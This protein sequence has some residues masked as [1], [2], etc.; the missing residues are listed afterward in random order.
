MSNLTR[1]LFVIADAEHAR[2]VRIAAN[3]ALHTVEAFDSV[4][5]HRRPSDLGSDH[6]GAA[7]HSTS[8][9]H[10]AFVPR[11]DPQ[12]VASH[13][14][15]AAIS[16]E[17]NMAFARG[18]FDRLVLAALPHTA[19]VLSERLST[20]AASVLIGTLDKDLVKTP[21]DALSTHLRAWLL[22]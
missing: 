21:D 22:E 6:P 2:F 16:D 8:T 10:H 13:Q 12:E 14:F 18:E 11:H 19:Q 5:V 4:A 15:A 7:F 20:G 9:A 17:I 1:S 3:G